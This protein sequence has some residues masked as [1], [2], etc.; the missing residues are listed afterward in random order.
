MATTMLD[1]EQDSIN[2]LAANL[3]VNILSALVFRHIADREMSLHCA[4]EED[5]DVRSN[6]MILSGGLTDEDSD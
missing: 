1:W 6:T 2:A 5:E 4:L 3:N